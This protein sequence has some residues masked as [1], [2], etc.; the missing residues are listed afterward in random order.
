MT[1]TPDPL[2][3]TADKAIPSV[4]RCGELLPSL[5][6]SAESSTSTFNMCD[7]TLMLLVSLKSGTAGSVR[8][9]FSFKLRDFKL[10]VPPSLSLF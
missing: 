9:A 4:S 10:D 1:E 8:G 2:I 3:V 6:Y 5:K 7:V